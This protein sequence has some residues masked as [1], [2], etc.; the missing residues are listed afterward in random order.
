MIG[1]CHELEDLAGF[2]FKFTVFAVEAFTGLAV[3]T[4]AIATRFMLCVT[5]VIIQF[6]FDSRRPELL[7]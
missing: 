7:C 6:S 1:K 2:Y 5:Q 4:T 3:T